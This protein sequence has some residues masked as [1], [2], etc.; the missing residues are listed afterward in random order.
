GLEHRVEAEAAR[1]PDR[2]H[3]GALDTAL[4][5]GG[6]AVGPGHRQVAA[7]EAAPVGRA[8]QLLVDPLHGDEKVP[9]GPRPA[10]GID[11]RLAAEGGDLEAGIVGDGRQ[12]GGR[13]GGARLQ[14]R[15]LFEV[16]AGFL[17]LRQA[18]IAGRQHLQAIGRQQRRVLAVL[19]GVV[20]GQHQPVAGPEAPDGRVVHRVLPHADPSALAWWAQISFT[21]YSAR[22]SSF[23]NCPCVNGTSSAVPC[24]ST[25]PPLA[26]STKLASAWQ[27]ESSA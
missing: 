13:A 14:N 26:V 8:A 9:S 11:A 15:V 3:Q 21:P 24:T 10:G 18:E 16:Q 1:A 2:P 4:E 25:T 19:A 22:L 5:R 12:S 20:G 17:G 23:S 7:K 6:G 27:V